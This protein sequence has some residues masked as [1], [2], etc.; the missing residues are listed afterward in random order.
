MSKELYISDGCRRLGYT[1]END[2]DPRYYE[3]GCGDSFDE[4]DL[5]IVESINRWFGEDSYNVVCDTVI[6]TENQEV[7][8]CMQD[9]YGIAPMWFDV[10]GDDVTTVDELHRDDWTW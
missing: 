5:E 9:D 3:I 1:P 2:Y 7:M 8:R 4:A 10:C 6:Y